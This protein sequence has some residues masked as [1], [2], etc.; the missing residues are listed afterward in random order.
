MKHIWVL[1]TI[2]ALLMGL[3]TLS[4]EQEATA[5]L[6]NIGGATPGPAA[7]L[8]STPVLEVPGSVKVFASGFCCPSGL[9]FGPDG[10]LYVAEAGRGGTSL[11]GPEIGGVK[12]PIGPYAGGMTARISRVS[13]D[14]VRTTVIE[15]LPSCQSS[16]QSGC[17]CRGIADV[18]FMGTTLYA[19][20]SGA[21]RSHGHASIPNGIIRVDGY[22]RWAV[23]ADLSQFQKAHPIVNPDN[24]DIEPDGLWHSMANVDGKFYALEP[25][26]GELDEIDPVTRQI[27]RVVDISASQGHI[28][29]SAVVYRAGYFY[30]GNLTSPP[31]A[32]GRA[33]IYRISRSGEVTAW[34]TG[35]TDINGM[36]FDKR[37]RLYVLEGRKSGVTS[38]PGTGDIVRVNLGG[39]REM[40]VTGLTMPTALTFGPDGAL[41]VSNKGHGQ[42]MA[43]S[44]EI[45]RITERI[46]D[47]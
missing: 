33:S 25:N 45:L 40:I 36:A 13:P 46:E 39:W 10:Y 8:A 20:L 4:C 19:L 23:V 35:F 14:G 24:N 38:T 2:T 27:S 18:E 17:C 1:A 5:P 44:G 43:G 21:G 28:D 11:I 12:P 37:G 47:W 34:A 42:G 30:V 22:S 9:T 3:F 41:Y 32:D 26:H 31:M 15:S 7:T 6:D 16:Y 29:P